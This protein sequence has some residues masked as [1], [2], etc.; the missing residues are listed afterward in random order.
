M[1]RIRE[2][3]LK[4]VV[5]R[6]NRAT[7]NPMEQYTEKNGEFIHNAGNFH[8]DSAYGGHKLEQSLPGGGVR[9]VLDCGFETKRTLYNLMF[10]YLN[11]ITDESKATDEIKKLESD[12]T[13][14]DLL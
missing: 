4:K 1:D 2:S 3:D 10:A 8:L 14:N 9:N 11:G 12:N 5:D 13:I 7:N 6:I